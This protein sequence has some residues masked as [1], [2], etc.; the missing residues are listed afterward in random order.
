MMLLLG[1][2]QVI[3]EIRCSYSVITMII[4]HTRMCMH[5]RLRRWW[6][7]S[8]MPPLYWPFIIYG[9]THNERVLFQHYWQLHTWHARPKK[10]MSKWPSRNIYETETGRGLGVESLPFTL[11]S[12]NLQKRI[13]NHLL[14]YHFCPSTLFPSRKIITANE[15]PLHLN[16]QLSMGVFIANRQAEFCSKLNLIWYETFQ[17]QIIDFSINIAAWAAIVLKHTC[18]I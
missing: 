14:S 6:K 10:D 1:W 18:L 12:Q 11:D 4:L 3:S 9:D 7:A 15:P 17:G 2:L 8:T 16:K 5:V 13:L